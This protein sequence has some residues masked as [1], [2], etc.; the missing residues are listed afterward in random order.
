MYTSIGLGE[1]ILRGAIR[2]RRALRLFFRN[3]DRRTA[4]LALGGLLIVLLWAS[5]PLGEELTS[6]VRYTWDPPE[7]GSSVVH[8]ILEL[9][10]LHGNVFVRTLVVDSIPENTYLVPVKQGKKYHVH[11]AGVDALNR[12]GP[13]SEWSE[14]QAPPEIVPDDPP[15]G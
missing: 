15:S 9:E 7:T 8:Y 4:G 12:Q 1:R 6:E 11:V 10:Q 3:H 5:N 14:I 13:W 2:M